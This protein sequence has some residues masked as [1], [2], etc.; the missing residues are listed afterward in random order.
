MNLNQAAI[1]SYLVQANGEAVPDESL[2]ASRLT[3]KEPS[4]RHSQQRGTRA[5]RLLMWERTSSMFG[6]TGPASN[7]I[8]L[9]A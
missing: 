4:S 1:E 3:C 9:Q 5:R 7:T 8:T 6:A 2:H